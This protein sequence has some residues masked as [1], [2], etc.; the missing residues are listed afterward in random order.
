MLKIHLK[1]QLCLYMYR[2]YLVCTMFTL[3]R[4]IPLQN[5]FC[6]P[7][8]S[9]L[10][11]SSVICSINWINSTLSKKCNRVILEC[12][13]KV[14]ETWNEEAGNSLCLHFN[15]A[16]FLTNSCQRS[17][18]CKTL[19]IDLHWIGHCEANIYRMYEQSLRECL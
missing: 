11:Y 13:C 16:K 3:S 4:Y 8:A 2:T 19:S 7:W 10:H 18:S 6:Y 15:F 5:Y 14:W 9:C 1:N 17:L 12:L